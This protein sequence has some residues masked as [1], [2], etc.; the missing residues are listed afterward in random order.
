MAAAALASS[1]ADPGTGSLKHLRE[2]VDAALLALPVD[3][4]AATDRG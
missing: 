2:N 1:A 3:N 4:G